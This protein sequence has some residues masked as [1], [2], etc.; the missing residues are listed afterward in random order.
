MKGYFKK[1]ACGLLVAAIALSMAAC[2]QG[3]SSS[4]AGSAQAASTASGNRTKITFWHITPVGSDGYDSLKTLIENFNSVQD[5][6]EVEQIG[7]PFLDY[8]SKMTTAFS[9]GVAPDVF[10]YTL[11]DVPVRAANGTIMDLTPYINK[12]NYSL[13]DFYKTEL[14]FGAYNGQQYALPFSSTCRLLYYNL[15]MF[16]EAGLT[17][18]DVPKTWDDL[19]KV[20]HKMDKVNS[21]TIERLGFDPT[22]GQSN[23]FSF[24]WQDGVDFFDKAGNP[25]L[26]SPEQTKVLQWM[27]DFN[28]Q[29][30]SAQ[31]QAFTDAG[32]TLAADPFVSGRLGMMVGV[33]QEYKVLQN[34]KVSFKYGVAPLPTPDSGAHVNWSSCWSIEAFKSKDQAK[35]DGAWEF[36]KY[37]E[38]PETQRGYY[39]SQGWLTAS[40][41]ANEGLQTDPIMKTI[42][43]E[44]PYSTEKRFLDYA[45]KWHEDWDQFMQKATAGTPVSEVLTEAQKFYLEKQ[46]NY[47]ATH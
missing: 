13:D 38:K 4:A 42:I 33:D 35:M 9:G 32:K 5:K 8:F 45:P 6:Y 22:A 7:Y 31:R 28:K 18:A 12:D 43:G 29:Y 26:T 11:D 30:P 25:I 37:M 27:V 39:D 24:L 36:I 34:S 15:D 44:L 23:Y 14:G 1:F 46:S 10:L 19:Y 21:G 47:K 3:G 16:K 40:K 17:E 41:T 2:G 20:A